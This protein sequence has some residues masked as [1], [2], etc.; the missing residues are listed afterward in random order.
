MT[1]GVETGF[2]VNFFFSLGGQVGDARKTVTA[3]RAFQLMNGLPQ[4]G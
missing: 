2:D 4:R 1:N 3:S